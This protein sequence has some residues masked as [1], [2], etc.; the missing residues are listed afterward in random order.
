[1]QNRNKNLFI[2]CLKKRHTHKKNNNNKFICHQSREKDEIDR[3]REKKKCLIL[4][5]GKT[6]VFKI[7]V[8]FSKLHLN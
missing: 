5:D 4:R 6:M 2:L 7:V 8:E 1:M 3:E